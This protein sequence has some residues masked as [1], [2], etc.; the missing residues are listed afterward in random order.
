MIFIVV[1]HALGYVRD[2]L[3]STTEGAAS[4]SVDFSDKRY[5]VLNFSNNIAA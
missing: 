4:R 2:D 5:C 3:I 1:E